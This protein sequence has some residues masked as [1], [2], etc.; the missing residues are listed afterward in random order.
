MIIDKMKTHHHY[1]FRK[2]QLKM[3]EKDLYPTVEKFLKSKKNCLS[4]YVGSDL[5]LK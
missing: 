4:E 3:H 2:A 1:L 5:S